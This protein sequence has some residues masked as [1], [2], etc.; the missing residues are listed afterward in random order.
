[1]AARRLIGLSGANGVEGRTKKNKKKQSPHPHARAC[2]ATHRL[3]HMKATHDRKG[4]PQQNIKARTTR[5]Q[6]H[7][8]HITPTHT[9]SLTP[10]PEHRVEEDGGGPGGLT[11][12][13]CSA[14]SKANSPAPCFRE[15]GPATCTDD[16]ER[17]EG[18]TV[19]GK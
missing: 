5:I 1:M 18:G 14:Y 8:T 2:M 12:P 13:A 19:G 15:P 7:H 10:Q 11:L 6:T 16:E 4:R 17:K 9:R 3:A